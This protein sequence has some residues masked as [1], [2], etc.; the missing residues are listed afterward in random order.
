[1]RIKLSNA[2]VISAGKSVHPLRE[3]NGLSLISYFL[4]VAFIA[5]GIFLLTWKQIYEMRLGY[6]IQE[7]EKEVKELLNENQI[8]KMKLMNFSSLEKIEDEAMGKMKLKKPELN[9]VKIIE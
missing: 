4:I 2:R 5:A 1:M 8:L 3:S 9:Q 7:K 6:R